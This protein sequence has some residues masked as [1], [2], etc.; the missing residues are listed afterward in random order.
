[1]KSLLFYCR[2]GYENDLANEV[3]V[4]ISNQDIAGHVI[5]K[6]DSG[7]INFVCYESD[8]VSWLCQHLQLQK[9]VFCRQMVGVIE[10][11]SQ[12]P[13]D[14]VSAII[15]V[16]AEHECFGNLRIEY[17]D[18]N[19]GRELAKF[20]KKF[21]V[22]MRRALRSKNLLSEKDDNDLPTLHLFFVNSAKVQV[23]FSFSHNQSQFEQGILRLKFPSDAPSRSVLKL[24][25]AMRTFVPK[26]LPHS[27]QVARQYAVDLGASP[28]GWTYFL[29]KQGFFV[30]AVDNGP[31]DSALMETG[32]VD[33]YMEDGF[34]F[35]PK[36]KNTH[37]LVCDM[38][39]KPQ[40][41]ARLM[42]DWIV[43]EWT[44][45]CI[46]NLKLPMKKRFDMVQ[47]CITDIHEQI[48]GARMKYFLTIKQLYHDRDEVTC[49]LTRIKR[50]HTSRR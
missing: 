19:E 2:A 13:D 41:V 4:K 21:T 26:G 22:P 36:K 24:E 43:N 29:V 12:L 37:L 45:H 6:P 17:P 42:A 16:L 8:H 46:F 23:G 27:G 25:E 35:E 18:T 39:E 38:V 40:R 30:S 32:Q 28:G 7:Y 44:E 3:Q 34:K 10:E 15:D 1:M 49:Y 31:M 48:S 11:I 9:L 20:C 5:A 47:Q 50:T 33:H 14:R